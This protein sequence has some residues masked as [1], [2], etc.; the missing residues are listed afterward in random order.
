[1][2]KSKVKREKIDSGQPNTP[3]PAPPESMEAVKQSI[4]EIKTINAAAPPKKRSAGKTIFKILCIVFF[5]ITLC[6]LGFRALFR[7]L[8]IGITAKTTAVFTVVFG[9]M[10]IGYAA[11]ILI[12]INGLAESGQ[13]VSAEYMQRLCITSVV[14]LLVFIV[15]G[16]VMGGFSSQYMISPVRKITRRV[17]EISEEN[18]SDRRLDPV[19]SQDELMELTEQ[20]NSMLDSLQQALDRQENFVSDASHELK[21]PISVIA[22]YANLLRRWGKDDPKVRDEAVDAILR[23][24]DN[25]KKLVE[26]LLWLAKLGDFTLDFSEFNLYE[27]LD[28]MVAAYRLV[29][30]KHTFTLSGD[31]SVT[32]NTDKNLL[33]EAVR[34]LIDNA[35]K[36]TPSENGVINISVESADD[37]FTVA[38]EDNGIGISEE[39]R[40]QIFERFYRCDKARSR[41]SGSCGLGL[42]ICKSIVE[43]LGGKITVHSELG[44]GSKFVITVKGAVGEIDKR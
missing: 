24:S 14:L 32:V 23:E 37:M 5:P 41:K 9:L 18:I 20:I 44:K 2:K 3:R 25:M 28:D 17:K 33:T 10:L 38:V 13:P 29:N 15:L 16:A 40:Q 35:I 11:F 6:V 43:N 26:Q 30:T 4:L 7:K 21:T 36:Y 22:G 39:D 42:T 34:T 27:E 8:K 1:M 12:S 31:P 19:D